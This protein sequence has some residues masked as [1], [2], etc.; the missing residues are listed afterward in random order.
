MIRANIA[1]SFLAA[2][3][4]ILSIPQEGTAIKERKRRMG[5]AKRIRAFL[6]PDMSA[7]DHSYPAVLRPITQQFNA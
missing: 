1:I 5:H 4:T 2:I 7:H 3:I 6:K